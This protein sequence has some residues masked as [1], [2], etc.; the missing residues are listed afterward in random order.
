VFIIGT[1]ALLR[2]MRRW[3]PAA[4]AAAAAAAVDQ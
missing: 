2:E 1:V 4:A 3:I